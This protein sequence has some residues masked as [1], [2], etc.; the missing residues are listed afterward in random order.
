MKKLAIVGATGLVGQEV[1]NVLGEEGLL[2]DFEPFLIVSEKSAGKSVML[3]GNVCELLKLD[4]SVISTGFDFAIFLTD[5]KISKVW[6]PEFV[7]K[8]VIVIDNSCAFR[9]EEDVP[10]VVPEINLGTIKQGD[11]LISNPNCS[12]IQLVIVLDRLNKLQRIKKVVVSSYQSVSGAGREALCDLRNNTRNVFGAGIQDNLI[13]CIGGLGAGNNC[14][15]ENKIIFESK[16]ILAQ[17]FDIYATTVRVPISYCHGESV[18]VEFDGEIDLQN[19]LKQLSCPHILL[20][21]D[22]FYPKQ[23]V[24]TN[25]TYVFRLRQVEKNALM[26]FVLADNL[27]RGAAYNAVKILK[28]INQKR[29]N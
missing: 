18:Y 19:V 20:S 14:S 21:Q 16:K 1:L 3:N 22:L 28:E 5:E 6:I 4:E 11:K 2:D 9:L 13:A 10:L 26:F 15:E 23:C 27:R 25:L 17:D 12:T 24:G 7:K 8:G 29:N